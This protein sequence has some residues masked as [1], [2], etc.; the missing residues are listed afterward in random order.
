MQS[1]SNRQK[2]GSETEHAVQEFS[3]SRSQPRPSTG[4]GQCF[5]LDRR[6]RG[7][8]V[9][10]P[11]RPGDPSTVRQM[12]MPK[13]VPFV[14]RVHGLAVGHGRGASKTAWEAAGPAGLQQGP[15]DSQQRLSPSMNWG[16]RHTDRVNRC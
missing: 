8:P 15:W 13:A 16:K 1:A 6:V 4:Q 14:G 3:L 9:P 11:A 5:S 7:I 10:E 12:R 2:A